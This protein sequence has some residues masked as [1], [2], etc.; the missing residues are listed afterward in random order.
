MVSFLSGKE[1]DYYGVL[2]HYSYGEKGQK[3]WVIHKEG[4]LTAGNEGDHTPT[5][6]LQVQPGSSTGHTPGAGKTST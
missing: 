1:L 4:A 3:I 2:F 5:G 6:L